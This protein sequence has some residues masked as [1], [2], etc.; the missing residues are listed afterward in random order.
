MII[1]H[2]KKNYERYSFAKFKET[3]IHAQDKVNA[4]CEFF[5]KAGNAWYYGKDFNKTLADYNFYEN[6]FYY[7]RLCIDGNF[8]CVSPFVEKQIFCELSSN[9]Y[10]H[11]NP[12][13]CT[14]T[15]RG[16]YLLKTFDYLGN[17]INNIPDSILPSEFYNHAFKYFGLF[18][19]NSLYKIFNTADELHTSSIF[20]PPSHELEDDPVHD[21]LLN[22]EDLD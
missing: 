19:T 15:E 5:I 13:N 1:S 4:L 21:Q 7:L 9:D 17:N 10:E 16:L 22:F 6:D 20:A 3:L 11:L 2:K 8:I 14:Y 12:L 18:E